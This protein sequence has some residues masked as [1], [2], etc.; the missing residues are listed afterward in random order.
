MQATPGARNIAVVPVADAVEAR[1]LLAP[2]A[3]HLSVVAVAGDFDDAWR[4]DGF[5]GRVTTPGAM[6]DPPL[7]GMEDLRPPRA[8]RPR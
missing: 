1:T 4:P 2:Y 5:A 3:Q 7:D 8:V 6:Q